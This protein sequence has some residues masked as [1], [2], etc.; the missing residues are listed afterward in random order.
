[1]NKILL[2]AKEVMEMTGIKS[3]TTLA[4]L[5]NDGL[6]PPPVKLH[7]RLRRWH[8]N[9]ITSWIDTIAEEKPFSKLVELKERKK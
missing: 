6:M 7:K 9:I 3:P 2:T 5:V 8:I 1:M 4:Q